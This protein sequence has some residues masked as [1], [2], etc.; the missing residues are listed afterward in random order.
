MGNF[1]KW[2][3]LSVSTFGMLLT[4]KI[5]QF[6]CKKNEMVLRETAQICLADI[7]FQFMYDESFYII[8]GIVEPSSR[9]SVSKL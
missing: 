4:I 5:R 9:A 8:E 6:I 1:A 2:Q 7:G 3:H